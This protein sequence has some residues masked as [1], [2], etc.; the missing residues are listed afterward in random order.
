MYIGKLNEYILFKDILSL[1]SPLHFLFLWLNYA[2][3]KRKINYYLSKLHFNHWVNMN[4]KYTFL[5][6]AKLYFS[7]GKSFT[8]FIHIKLKPQKQAKT[9]MLNFCLD[10]IY[11][12]LKIYTFYLTLW[13]FNLW[14]KRKHFSLVQNLLNLNFL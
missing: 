13:E 8:Y 5:T 12:L 9:I 10:S 4:N 6:N 14:S 11:Q 2:D 1:N 7:F 3:N